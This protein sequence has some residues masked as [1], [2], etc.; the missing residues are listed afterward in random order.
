MSSETSQE[1]HSVS[2]SFNGIGFS[3]NQWEIM[4]LSVVMQRADL[5]RTIMTIL[6]DPDKSI[7]GSVNITNST[8]GQMTVTGRFDIMI[9]DCYLES[10]LFNT[11][12][13]KKGFHFQITNSVLNLQRSDVL[14][15]DCDGFLRAKRSVV[16]FENVRFSKC[17]AGYVTWVS[18]ESEVLMNSVIFKNLDCVSLQRIY[19]NIN[20]SGIIKDCSFINFYGTVAGGQNADV[21]ISKT[22]FGDIRPGSF[23]LSS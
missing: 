14:L 4:G 15:Y 20:S 18:D 23:L 17:V 7:R 5:K 6:E 21:L 3:Y 16:F 22:Y 1:E 12:S 19:I 11:T 2:V 8:F 9:S 13:P 10:N